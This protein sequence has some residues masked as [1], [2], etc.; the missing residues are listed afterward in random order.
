MT[1]ENDVFLAGGNTLVYLTGWPHTNVVE[2]YNICV[3]PSI[4]YVRILWPI[5]EPH[6]TLYGYLRI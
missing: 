5:F 6:S 3:G 4:Y 2:Y 1:E